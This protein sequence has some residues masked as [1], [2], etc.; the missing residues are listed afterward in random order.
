VEILL[1]RQHSRSLQGAWSM[2]NQVQLFLLLPLL[3]DSLSNDVAHFIYG[4]DKF[5]LSFNFIPFQNL[6]I[7]GNLIENFNFEQDDIN[8][9]NIGVKSES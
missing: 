6:P 2:I 9:K 7:F 3:I 4:M 5:S 1:Y 8:L